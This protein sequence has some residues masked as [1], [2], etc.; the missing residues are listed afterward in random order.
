MSHPWLCD[1]VAA[2]EID[3]RLGPFQKQGKYNSERSRPSHLPLQRLALGLMPELPSPLT[4][5]VMRLQMLSSY[6]CA[7][8][9]LMTRPWWQALS[10]EC[11]AGHYEILVY[12]ACALLVL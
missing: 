2:S 7:V 3:H 4:L 9:K 5:Y 1:P 10:W 6:E 12:L 8:P 11:G